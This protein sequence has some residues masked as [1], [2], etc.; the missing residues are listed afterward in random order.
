MIMRHRVRY[1]SIALALLLMSGAVPGTP[2]SAAS[3]PANGVKLSQ[4]LTAR[5]KEIARKIA[6]KE[7]IRNIILF[8]AKKGVAITDIVYSSIKAGVEP[9]Q[10][11][12]AAIIEGYSAR[13]VVAFSLRAGA[14][15]DKVV[16]AALGAGADKRFIYLGAT[17]AGVSVG[18]IASVVASNAAPAANV[19][20]PASIAP[21]HVPVYIPPITVS[22]GGGGGMTPSTR[23]ASP[24]RP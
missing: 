15:L 5:E 18:A 19:A 2:A 1:K 23:I 8:Y 20:D 3:M 6:A 4:K 21:A 9:G 13:P 24:Y 14:P 7:P 12:Y 11:V 10:V 17:D 16:E 22:M